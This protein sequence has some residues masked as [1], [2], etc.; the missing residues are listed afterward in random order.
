VVSSVSVEA[1]EEQ[2][3]GRIR[4]SHDAIARIGGLRAELKRLR[5]MLR[6]AK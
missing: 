4:Y 1:A 5:E 3:A 2:T 6:K